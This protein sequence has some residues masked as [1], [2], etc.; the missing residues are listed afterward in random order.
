MKKTLIALLALAGIATADTAPIDSLNNT[1]GTLIGSRANEAATASAVINASSDYSTL[2][3]LLSES[4]KWYVTSGYV[5]DLDGF[6]GHSSSA[7]TLAAGGPSANSASGAIKFTIGAETLAQ[8]EGPITLSFDVVLAGGN[9]NKNHT[10]TFALMGSNFST[11]MTFG[12]KSGDN[13]LTDKA[14]TVTLSMNAA[15]VEAMQATGADQT[16]VFLAASD[17]VTGSNRGV[18]MSNFS[19]NG[20]LIPEP[21]TATLSLLA[22]AG[23]AARR[24]RR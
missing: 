10:F 12:S 2:M 23:L 22:L 6:L 18:A 7:V 8:Y 21:T 11:A 19:L 24:R 15:Q 9:N 20:E 5:T 4:N 13:V 14:Q 1:Y 3:T 17:A 16:L